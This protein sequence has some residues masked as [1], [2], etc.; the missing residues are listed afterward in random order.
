LRS[1]VVAAVAATAALSGGMAALPAGWSGSPVGA[2]GSSTGSSGMGA[3]AAPRATLAPPDP[4]TCPATSHGAVVDRNNQRAWLCTDGTIVRVMAITSARSQPDPGVY[5]VYA[6]D[7]ETT[8]YY[9]E[10]P[11][12][13]DRFVAFTY[14][15]EEGA[16]VA[17]H[18]VPRY[19]DD[20]LAQP[21]ESVGTQA[22]FGDSSGCIRVRPVDSVAIWD[23][24]AVGD[25]VHVI[26]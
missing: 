16:R 23:H 2:P 9:G 4:T 24:L 21:L 5:A 20:T 10:R 18:A 19:S 8:S 1:A 12:T 17:F 22:R 13:L 6:E 26:S 7:M 25:Q 3:K 14:G 11:S 15:E